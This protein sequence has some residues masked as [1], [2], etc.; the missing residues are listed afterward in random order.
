MAGGVDALG[1]GRYSEGVTETNEMSAVG[2]VQE[3]TFT[4]SK[5]EVL[6]VIITWVVT[7]KNYC[8]CSTG[9]FFC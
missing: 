6:L 7:C 1:L 4:N 8:S 2:R 5:A 9:T 3:T